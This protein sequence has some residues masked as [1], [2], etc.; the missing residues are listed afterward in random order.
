MKD[1]LGG[2]LRRILDLYFRSSGFEGLRL[3][4]LTVGEEYASPTER[5]GDENPLAVG[6]GHAA[7]P[8]L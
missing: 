8:Q 2:C 6:K 4:G 1:R 5:D 3:R 7:G